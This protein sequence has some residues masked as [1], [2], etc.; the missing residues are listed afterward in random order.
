M[1]YYPHRSRPPHGCQGQRGV[2]RPALLAGAVLGAP[3]PT[4][5][6]TPTSSRGP[7]S[8]RSAAWTSQTLMVGRYAMPCQ[9]MGPA[10]GW[11]APRIFLLTAGVFEPDRVASQQLVPAARAEDHP[12]LRGNTVRTALGFA[13][14]GKLGRLL[15]MVTTLER[16]HSGQAFVRLKVGW[17]VGA[18]RLGVVWAG[19]QLDGHATLT[20]VA[21]LRL[22]V[23]TQWPQ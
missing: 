23:Q 6:P 16:T 15:V 21:A 3:L 2:H 8:R 5:Q 18:V 10:A 19:G 22:P 17:W 4:Q 7:G 14:S 1:P 20:Q 12:L 11:H 9:C 13:K